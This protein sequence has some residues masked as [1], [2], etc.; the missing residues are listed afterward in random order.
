M[1]IAIVGNGYVGLSNAVV[2][3]QHHRVQAVDVDARKVALINDRVSP[4]VDAELEHYLRE[5]PLTLTATTDGDLAYASA[6]LVVVATP[7]NYD[8]V[9]STSTRP[10]SR[11]W[12]PGCWR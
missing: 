4:I 11:A 9:T 3:A 6:E 12:W 10:A 1:K 7:T 8:A 5:V 2:L